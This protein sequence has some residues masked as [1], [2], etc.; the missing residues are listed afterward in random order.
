[1][2]KARWSGYEIDSSEAAYEVKVKQPAELGTLLREFLT[3]GYFVRSYY[4]LF[5]EPLERLRQF[6]VEQG[7]E[8]DKLETEALD[9]LDKQI[10]KFDPESYRAPHIGVRA[11]QALL[12]Y[13]GA[14]RQALSEASTFHFELPEEQKAMYADADYEF[15]PGEK[16]DETVFYSEDEIPL[17]GVVLFLGCSFEKASKLSS[18][19][20]KQARRI[21]R[22]AG[23]Q[24]EEFGA[25]SFGGEG[26]GDM[27]Q[28]DLER[29]MNVSLRVRLNSDA[30]FSVTGRWMEDGQFLCDYYTFLLEQAAKKAGAEVDLHMIY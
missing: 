16:V 26:W 8:E 24:M 12:N 17:D 2:L 25:S 21:A 3:S 7:H 20:Q 27:L 29:P 11:I 18:Q 28:E 15:T 1:M 4:L 30:T 14:H 5:E 13:V 23:K 19:E 10:A 6:I 9:Y 22:G